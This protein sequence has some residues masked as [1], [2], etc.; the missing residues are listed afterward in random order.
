MSVLTVTLTF[1]TTWTIYAL[2]NLL[3]SNWRITFRNFE[4]ISNTGHASWLDSC[5]STKSGCKGN[6]VWCCF[7]WGVWKSFL[8][9][10]LRAEVHTRYVHHTSQC[11]DLFKDWQQTILARKTWQLYVLAYGYSC[12]L[13]AS[14]KILIEKN[15]N[16]SMLHH[17]VC[18][19]A[20]Q[21]YML[22]CNKL[23]WYLISHWVSFVA[24][25][26]CAITNCS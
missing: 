7:S 20:S 24:H 11:K 14:T 6:R 25:D 4:Y 21:S 18:D 13:C 22:V 26:N 10:S 17:A 1:I 8:H 5:K 16:A 2:L 15:V 23:I 3:S 9:G 19:W 12:I